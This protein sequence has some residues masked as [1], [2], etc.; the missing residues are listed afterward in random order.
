MSCTICFAP[1][2]FVCGECKTTVYCSKKCQSIDFYTNK[3]MITCSLVG[4]TIQND[5]EYLSRLLPETLFQVL[6]Q[7]WK[8]NPAKAFAICN[9]SNTKLLYS[10]N[11]PSYIH[12]LHRK[13]SNY[14]NPNRGGMIGELLQISRPD[15][16][17]KKFPFLS[18]VLLQNPHED[19]DFKELVYYFR[20][21]RVVIECVSILHTEYWSWK[22]LSKYEYLTTRFIEQNLTKK[23]R[24]FDLYENPS[25]DFDYF[26]ENHFE[27]LEEQDID[28]FFRFVSRN[29]NMTEAFITRHFRGWEW[30]WDYLSSNMK[31]ITEVI[32]NKPEWP[33]VYRYVSK[34][35]SLTVDFVENNLDK[36]WNWR[37]LSSN[38]G[39]IKT[40][41]LERHHDWP[42]DFKLLSERAGIIAPEIIL[43]LREKDWDWTVVSYHLN[44]NAQFFQ[45]HIGKLPFTF[46]GLA[47]NENLTVD[48]VETHIKE[49]LS[50]PDMDQKWT[51]LSERM[52]LTEE[53]LEQLR[54][55]LPW[56]WKS[57]SKNKHL[58]PNFV[59]KYKKTIPWNWSSLSQN[60]AFDWKF[61]LDHPELPWDWSTDGLSGKND[62]DM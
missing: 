37:S 20:N 33:W 10:E 50:E 26:Y 24:W 60:P 52:I 11:T 19:W 59:L 8:N 43:K 1:S 44:A 55:D 49:F 22:E 16:R 7:I 5:A 29:P 46:Y 23:W 38:E 14:P 17:K 18:Y 6:L 62:I 39:F 51:W 54:T 41:A 32:S 13:C 40:G 12:T 15:L 9:L 27:I 45:D 3:H 47:Y 61:I 35:T 48:F 36:E 28:T 57:V 21:S 25:F 30:D 34:N 31:R 56:N 4:V 2:E 42:W 53:Y 58:S